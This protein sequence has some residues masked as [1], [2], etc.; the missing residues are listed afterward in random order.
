[1]FGTVC[2]EFIVVNSDLQAVMHMQG[3]LDKLFQHTAK[4]SFF[5]KKF[6]F[7]FPRKLSIFFWVKN[8]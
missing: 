7:D 2:V 8:S 3:G 5:V 1:M 6:K 4:S